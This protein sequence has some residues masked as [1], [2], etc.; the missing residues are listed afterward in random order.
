MC[1]IC[2]LLLSGKLS[3]LYFIF[4]ILE[5]L[6]L[7]RNLPGRI[8]KIGGFDLYWATNVSYAWVF[9]YRI[10]LTEGL[11]TIKWINLVPAMWE[12]MQKLC[13]VINRRKVGRGKRISLLPPAHNTTVFW[14]VCYRR[15]TRYLVGHL[16]LPRYRYSMD[17][18][19]GRY[20][21]VKSDSCGV[22][23]GDSSMLWCKGSGTSRC[24]GPGTPTNVQRK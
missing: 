22:R 23:A 6:D 20:V 24:S 15:C 16:Y 11:G 7:T 12:I 17:F 21:R 10:S 2:L 13:N 5:R 4:G 1:S 19:F 9:P 3:W 8:H 18:D 14:K